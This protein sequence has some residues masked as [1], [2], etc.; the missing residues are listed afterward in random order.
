VSHHTIER[1]EPRQLLSVADVLRID[2]GSGGSYR[3]LN[4]HAWAADSG[5]TGGTRV[6]S[7]ASIIRTTDDALYASYETGRAVR[8]AKSVPNGTY[9]L[10]LRF[11]DVTST[12]AGQR[13]FDVWAEGQQV[14]NDLD[15]VAAA[16][17]ARA[18]TQVFK[19]SIAD[20]VLNVNFYGVRGDAVVS[21]IALYTVTGPSAPI[22]LRAAAPAAGQINLYW[23]DTTTKETGFLVER[24]P[25]TSG[26]PAWTQI[27]KPG[28][29]AASYSDASLARSTSYIYRVRAYHK[30]DSTTMEFSDYSDVVTATTNSVTPG[31]RPGSGNTGPTNA[32]ILKS[33]GSITIKT[34]GAVLENLNIT[35]S[36]TIAAD[37]V[38]IRNFRVRAT[39]PFCINVLD[40]NGGV[41]IEDGDLDG[42]GTTSALIA[43]GGFTARR[44]NL[45][46]SAADGVNPK[47]DVTLDRCWIHQI[48]L[49]PASHADGVQITSGA[50]FSFTG[51]FFDLP[52]DQAGTS[53]NS[54]VFLKEDSGTISDVTIDRN[55][56]NGG[57]YTIY[58]IQI[59][60]CRVTN[61]LFGRDYRFGLLSADGS[62]TWTN[63]RWIDTGATIPK[64]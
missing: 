4:G 32:S 53:S 43:G 62:V 15:L 6:R 13:T 51:N 63:N 54:A 34:P 41:I 39:G 61:N 52:V 25:A 47:G 50:H 49:N 58:S 1:L 19:V 45:H 12:G 9:T 5:F 20:G 2:A 60:S 48:G 3:D 35:G 17:P 29:N 11:A 21:G 44:L 38:V 40:G 33:S 27:G 46:G 57:N 55:W 14:L 7:T 31:G 16:G 36:I 64:P 42:A 10:E 28:K 59:G 18:Y 8:F 37:S 23:T 24:A 22:N 30:I 56:L 26:A